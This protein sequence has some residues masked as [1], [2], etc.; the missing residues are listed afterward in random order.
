MELLTGA[1]YYPAKD[2]E[3]GVALINL[4]ISGDSYQFTGEQ[5]ESVWS[6]LTARSHCTHF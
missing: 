6:Y 1:D 2:R 4:L 3:D 5:A